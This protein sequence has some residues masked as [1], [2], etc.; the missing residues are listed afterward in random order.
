MFDY[1]MHSH[2]SAD[3]SVS[4]EDMV[5]GAIKKGLSE[6]CFTEHIDYDYPDKDF[7]FEFDLTKYHEQIKDLQ[8]KYKEEIT[9]KKGV[10]LGLQPYLLKRYETLMNEEIFDF[11]IASI[12]TA[13]KKGLHDGEFFNGRSI[14]ESYEIYYEELLDCVKNFKAFS[15]L[16]HLDLVKRYTVPKQ[17]DEKFHEI[18][19]EIFREIIP[20]GKGIELNTSGKKYGL[21]SGMPSTDILNLYKDVGGE[22]ITLGSDAHKESEQATEFQES[23]SLLDSLGFKYIATFKEMKPSFHAINRL[24]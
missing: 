9:I 11:V 22:I 6:I 24:M 19:R 23:L 15:I 13:D 18:I 20:A 21:T 5:R 16:G 8:K 1:H 14:E 3:C 2:F 10:E 7:V 17:P 12:H 4:T